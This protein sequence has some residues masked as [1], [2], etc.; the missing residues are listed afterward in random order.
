MEDPQ[1]QSYTVTSSRRLSQ[2]TRRLLCNLLE[3]SEI[4][5]TY[6][7]YSPCPNT[8]RSRWTVVNVEGTRGRL[9]Y[10]RLMG[11]RRS[12]ASKRQTCEIW[13]AVVNGVYIIHQL[14]A[15]AEP[16]QRKSKALFL[17]LLI[18]YVTVILLPNFDNF[19]GAI[20]LGCEKILACM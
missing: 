11:N 4:F 13:W 7:Y 3:V 12:V 19:R 5:S 15:S 16:L 8:A 2:S 17:S 1:S 18:W 14:R 10:P 6:S 9:C 20:P